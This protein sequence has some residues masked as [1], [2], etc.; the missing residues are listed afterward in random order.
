MQAAIWKVD[1]ASNHCITL[2]IQWLFG[3]QIKILCSSCVIQ[4]YFIYVTKQHVAVTETLLLKQ[5]TARVHLVVVL[6]PVGS[7]LLS[8]QT[9][10]TNVSQI[11]DRLNLNV[12]P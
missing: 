4:D 11:H 9:G 6:L 7:M 2:L 3:A 1:L 8:M 12:N 10:C 5:L